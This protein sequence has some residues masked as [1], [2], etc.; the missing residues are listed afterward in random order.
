[1]STYIYN[2]L[3]VTWF[4]SRSGTIEACCNDE[5]SYDSQIIIIII[6]RNMSSK[7]IFNIILILFYSDCKIKQEITE[8][9]Y[10]KF[11]AILNLLLVYFISIYFMF[12]KVH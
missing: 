3:S 12:R 10:I 5:S 4:M 7:G 8:Y 11:S 6:T 9:E 2:L 1:M